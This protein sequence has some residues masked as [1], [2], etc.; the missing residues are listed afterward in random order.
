LI[1]ALGIRD[2]GEVLA[3]DLARHFRDLDEFS[4]TTAEELISIENVGP[5]TAQSIVDW[6]SRPSNREFVARL[7]AAGVW[8]TGRAERSAD[9]G[10]LPLAGLTF[11]IT[12]TLP[13]YSR[14][15]VKELIQS[16]GGKVT[17]SV[18]KKTSYLVAG[19]SAGSKL[20]KARELGVP[21]LDEPA[22]L[23]LVKE[24]E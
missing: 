10:N 7:K 16:V 5:N 23:A 4:Q 1:S 11:V 2:V 21:I 22:L 15:G 14:D 13:N 19:E 8:S 17:D 20:D 9:Q 3:A 24:K 18:T 6:F 12:G